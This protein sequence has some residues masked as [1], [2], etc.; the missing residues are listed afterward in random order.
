MNWTEI[1]MIDHDEAYNDAA[2]ESVRELNERIRTLL[3]D[4]DELDDRRAAVLTKPTAEIARDKAK[5]EAELGGRECELLE[6]EQALRADIESFFAESDSHWEEGG[7]TVADA[8]ERAGRWLCEAFV[9]RDDPLPP[10]VDGP[11]EPFT[12]SERQALEHKARAWLGEWDNPD[13]TVGELA[14]HLGV[15]V[16]VAEQLDAWRRDRVDIHSHTKV[17]ES[18][19]ALVKQHPL[20]RDAE[21]S[22]QRITRFK[23]LA[24]RARQANAA[25]RETAAARVDEIREAIAGSIGT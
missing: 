13:A 25:A 22:Q 8:R 3:H 6:T 1:A 5:I 2:C 21:R 20:V 23:Q 18:F 10:L 17:R 9:R 19:R 24:H 11:L 12:E 16:N 7:L 15:P 4:R 14:Q